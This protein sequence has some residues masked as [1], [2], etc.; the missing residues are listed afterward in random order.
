LPIQISRSFSEYES[1]RLPDADEGA[2]LEE[3]AGTAERWA[4][5]R[6]DVRDLGLNFGRDFLTERAI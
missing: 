1:F 3:T 4:R 5:M 6:R 2:A